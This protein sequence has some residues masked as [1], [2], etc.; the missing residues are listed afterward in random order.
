MIAMK[1]AAERDFDFDD[2]LKIVEEFEKIQLA[3]NVYYLHKGNEDT[4]AAYGVPE[5]TYKIIFCSSSREVN[6][7]EKV[8]YDKISSVKKNRERRE[9]DHVD[10]ME[11]FD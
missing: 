9:R 10:I 8:F 2:F 4:I 7:I 3:K 6:S 11:M 1:S 5:G